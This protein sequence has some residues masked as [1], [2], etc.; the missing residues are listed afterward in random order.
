MD[1]QRLFRVVFRVVRFIPP[2]FRDA[3][4]LPA[5]AFAVRAFFFAA[6]LRPSVR[7]AAFF[8]NVFNGFQLSVARM[9]PASLTE[10]MS[11]MV[12]VGKVIGMS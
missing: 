8:L 10:V 2:A 3:L 7:A 1:D 5:R 9:E 6:P 11:A 12:T 4:A